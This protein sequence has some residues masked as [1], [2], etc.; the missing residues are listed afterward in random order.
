MKQ[1]SLI[2]FLC[3]ACC[4]AVA[5]FQ[6]TDPAAGY[7]QKTRSIDAGA[8]GEFAVEGAGVKTCGDYLADR[9]QQGALH[10]INLNWAKGFVTGVNYVR[11]EERHGSRLGAGLDLDA[12][13][14]Y[15]DNYCNGHADATLSDASVA[16]VNELM[17]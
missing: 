14:L 8:T 2:V 16:L 1:I 17:N 6:L 9:K 13:T 10:F 15:L 11:M 3:L 12:L 4:P 5:D 7:E